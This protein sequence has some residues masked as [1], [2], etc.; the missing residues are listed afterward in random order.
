MRILLDYFLYIF[1]IFTLIIIQSCSGESNYF[2]LKENV[3]KSY[4]IFF[5]DKENK[6]NTLNNSILV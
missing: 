1:K 6:K 4:N 5:T 3:Q 2:P